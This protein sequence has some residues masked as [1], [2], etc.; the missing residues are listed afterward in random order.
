MPAIC[1]MRRSLRAASCTE[2]VGILA[3]R[4]V[5]AETLRHADDVFVVA[6]VAPPPSSLLLGASR[7]AVAVVAVFSLRASR[8]LRR[9]PRLRLWLSRLLLSPPM[10]MF[11]AARREER[12]E[13]ARCSYGC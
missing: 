10:F 9:R 13:A 12:R 11:A 4:A 1:F 3:H 7:H 8:S 2:S 5:N 6:R